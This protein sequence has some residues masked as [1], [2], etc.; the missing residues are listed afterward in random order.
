MTKSR[1]RIGE[2]PKL[3]APAVQKNS[4]PAPRFKTGAFVRAR[5]GSVWYSGFIKSICHNKTGRF[6]GYAVAFGV[7]T[8]PNQNKIEVLPFVDREVLSL[9]AF[10]A[11][12]GSMR[13]VPQQSERCFW[14]VTHNVHSHS[15]SGAANGSDASGSG[16]RESERCLWYVTYNVH[17]HSASADSTVS[18]ATVLGKSSA[19]ARA[20]S[21]PPKPFPP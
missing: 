9:E 14:Y 12:P 5:F 18:G 19:P 10:N 2:V 8:F 7:G 6:T 21:K 16:T 17:S 13:L 11:G 3:N 15:A 1:R 4:V 20:L